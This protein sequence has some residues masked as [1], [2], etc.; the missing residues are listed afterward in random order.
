M[1]RRTLWRV[2]VLLQLVAFIAVIALGIW[3]FAVSRAPETPAESADPTVTAF[4]KSV[5][6]SLATEQARGTPTTR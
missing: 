4:V 6:D 2:G 1:S 3:W 5:K